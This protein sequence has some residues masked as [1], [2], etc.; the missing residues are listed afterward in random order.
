MIATVLW[1]EDG[2]VGVSAADVRPTDD[3][4]TETSTWSWVETDPGP[5]RLPSLDSGL[6]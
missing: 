1:R 5:W 2:K 3:K 6:G 4:G